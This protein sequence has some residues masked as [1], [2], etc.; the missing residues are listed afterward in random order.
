[1]KIFYYINKFRNSWLYRTQFGRKILLTIVVIVFVVIVV[2]LPRFLSLQAS[3]SFF[4]ILMFASFLLLYKP[5]KPSPMER[6]GYDLTRG[7][8]QA[9]REE[10]RRRQEHKNWQRMNKFFRR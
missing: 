1:M 10:A 3:I 5:R 9:L 6:V 7:Q 8:Q 4:L 2:N